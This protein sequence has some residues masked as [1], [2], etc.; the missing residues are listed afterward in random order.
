MMMDASRARE[1]IIRPTADKSSRAYIKLN[2]DINMLTVT[3]ECSQEDEGPV[4]IFF[5]PN[6]LI[7][8]PARKLFY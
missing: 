6:L 5:F 2:S 4:F 3:F 1:T 8:N 7:T